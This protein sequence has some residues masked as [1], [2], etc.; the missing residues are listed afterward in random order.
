MDGRA[1]TARVYNYL[2]GGKDNFAVDREAA[3][4]II[5]SAPDAPDVAR[6][7][8]R[9]AG[10]AASWA[11]ATHGIKR[12]V[13]IGVGISYGVPIPSVETCVKQADPAAK[14]IGFDPD[15]VVLAHARAYRPG[16]G[17]VLHGDVTDL[18]GIFNHPAADLIDTT[19][20]IVVVLAAVLHFIK[21]A[22]AVMDEL[23]ERLAAGSVVVLS[24][25]TST[26]TSQGRVAGMT[27]A[28][29]KA[30]SQIIF[31]PEEEI[32]ALAHGWDIV[33][34]PDLVDVQRWS[35]DGSY[36]GPS[37]ETV[38]VVGM[39]AVLPDHRPEQNHTAG[40]VQ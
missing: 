33:T 28:Y 1:S 32:R 12:V 3:E 38:R 35:P 15:E 23:S 20:P 34:P 8:L 17:G 7:N 18:D 5:R 40:A 14:V 16:Y 13:D 24:H 2:L 39:A 27:K 19:K 29:K 25:A 6:E 36:N 4:K 11:V 26:D 37:H 31:R 9:F 10:R 22:T 30:S 21:D